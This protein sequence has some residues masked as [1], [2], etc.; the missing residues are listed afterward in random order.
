MTT[1][2]KLSS[3]LTTGDVVLTHGMQV[4]LDREVN[5][6]PSQNGGC[7]ASRGRVVNIDTLEDDWLV[8]FVK[9]DRREDDGDDV[10]WTIQGNDLVT[11]T[12][13]DHEEEHSAWCEGEPHRWTQCPSFGWDD[14][15]M[16]TK[17]VS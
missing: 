7:F 12:I 5:A 3:Q 15:G 13:V 8:R 2:T 14:H 17:V 11:W 16:F 1:A 10:R 6:Y 4:E 9:S